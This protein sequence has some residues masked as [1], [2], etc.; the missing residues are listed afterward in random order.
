MIKSIHF[1]GGAFGI[2]GYIGVLNY[3]EKITVSLKQS[4]FQVHR[5]EQFL[6]F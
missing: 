4:N 6:H 1:G 3:F 5:L 2:I